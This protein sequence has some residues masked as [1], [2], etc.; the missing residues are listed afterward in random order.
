MK[1]VGYAYPWDVLDAPG[2]VERAAEVGVDEVAVALAYHS[3]RAATPWSSNRASVLAPHAA[4][5]RPLRESAWPAGGLRPL[6]ESWTAYDDAGGDAVRALRDAGIATAAWLVLTHNSALGTRHPEAAVCDCFGQLLPWALC[7]SVPLVQEYAARLTAESLDGLEVASVVL[8]ACGQLGVVH[9]HQHEKTDQVWSPAAARLLSVCCCE[10]CAA[11]WKDRGADP[12]EVRRRLRAEVL[13]LVRADDLTATD[14][15]LGDDLRAVL[16]QTRQAATDSL[17]A[18]VV[19]A[20]PVGIRIVLHAAADP[21]EVGAMPGLTPAV[22]NEVDGVVVRCWDPGPGSI[23]KVARTRGA[24]PESVTIGAYVTGLGATPMPAVADF[25]TA[26]PRAGAEELH[27]YHLGLTGPARLPILA[28]IA[29][30]ARHSRE[31]D[32]SN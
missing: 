30:V 16:L 27:L 25:V 4:L 20:V 26:L 21:W 31:L 18:E 23:E 7:P 15:E 24:L 3:V 9:Q 14:D 8:E 17:R 12:S 28:T 5:Y 1:V 13:R 29:A 2:F 6:G 22:A 10:A 19:R 11:G 32:A